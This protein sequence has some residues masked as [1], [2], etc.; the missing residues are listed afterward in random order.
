MILHTVICQSVFFFFLDL[1]K[2]GI[3]Y[4][5][6]NNFPNISLLFFL[7]VKYF[8]ILKSQYFLMKPR[9]DRTVRPEKPQ[10]VHLCGSF[11]LKNRSMRKK[12]DPCEP[13]SDLTVLRTVIRPLLTVPYFPLYLTSKIKNKKATKWTFQTVHGFFGQTWTFCLKI[14][15]ENLSEVLNLSSSMGHLVLQKPKVADLVR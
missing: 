13:R 1:S 15:T 11:S 9:P 14:F 3:I 4:N 5:T 6:N 7:E 2:Y 10:T 8:L 12:R